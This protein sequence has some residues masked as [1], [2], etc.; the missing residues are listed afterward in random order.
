M[1]IILVI[2]CVLYFLGVVDVVDAADEQLR[3]SKRD[4]QFSIT[5]GVGPF[6]DLTSTNPEPQPLSAPVIDSLDLPFF[7]NPGF[8]QPTDA[9]DTSTFGG[10]G[11]GENFDFA[12]LF[13]QPSFSESFQTGTGGSPGTGSSPLILSPPTDA[14]S[15]SGATG[16][17][18]PPNL[19]PGF[20][21]GSSGSSSGC[22][23]QRSGSVCPAVFSPVICNGNCQYGNSCVAKGAGFVA[24]QCRPN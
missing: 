17:D 21:G 6:Y 24:K 1:K 11:G 5:N 18:S 12:S 22:P 3:G 4:L 2:S 23:G 10:F 7:S 20:G 13:V 9:A 16:N 14:P 15:D 8:L 19:P